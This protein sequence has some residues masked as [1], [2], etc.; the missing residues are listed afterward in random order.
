MPG[1]NFHRTGAR[2][3]AAVFLVPA[4]LAMLS[5]CATGAGNGL[6]SAPPA[7]MAEAVGCEAAFKGLTG[8]TFVM[9]SEQSGEIRSCNAERAAVRFLPASTYKVPHAIIALEVGAA[10]GPDEAMAWDGATRAVAAWNR[11]AT[12]ESALRNSVVWYYQSIA[13]RIGYDRMT[14]KLATLDYGN[15]EIGG[16]ESLTHFWLDG[17]LRISALEQVRFLDRLRRGELPASQ[18]TQAIVRDMMKIRDLPGGA[19]HAKSGL[20]LPIDPDTGDTT[21]D[22][23]VTEKVNAAGKVGWYVGWVERPTEQGGSVVFA[24]N[25]DVTQPTDAGRRSVIAEQLLM[26]NGIDLV[27]S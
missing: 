3:S 13:R 20:V 24:V 1:I 5:G 7:K 21:S 23:L 12:L 16:P 8:G 25:I 22:P 4:L 9:L 11:D 2:R 27:G 19:L 10:K 26:A 14:Q 6:V 17:A 15:G 18:R